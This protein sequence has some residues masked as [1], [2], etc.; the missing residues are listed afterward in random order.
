MT[1]PLHVLLVEDS[2]SDAKLVI[3]EL[4]KIGRPIE[5]ERV[6]TEHS[7]R[8]ALD[9]RA[10]DLVISD[11]SMP[12]FSALAALAVVRGKEL[13]LPFIIVSGTIGE[14]SAVEAMRAGAND[15]VLKD[16][17]GRLAPAIERELRECEER[18]AH[19]LATHE[20]R[21]SEARFGR[22]AESAEDALRRSE[23]QLRQA[24]KME[25]VGRLA[26]GV[27]HD[28]NNIL[29]IILS[30]GELALRELRPGD[31]V[32][33][34]IEQ[35]CN[36]AESA[37][38]LTNQLLMFSRQRVVEPKVLELYQVVVNMEP[39]LQRIVGEDVKL[40]TVAPRS[41]G[42]VKVDPSHI[43]QVILNLIVN[44][45]DAMPKGG[46][47]TI[48]SEDVVLDEGY[49]R[50]HRP[51]RAGPHVMLAVSDT[52]AGMDRETQSRIFE[53][54]FTTKEVGKGTGLGLSTVFGIVQQSGGS[55]WVYSELGQGSTFKVFLPRVDADVDLPKRPSAPTTLHG[56]ETI[57]VVEDDERVREV[58][59]N[60]LERQGYHVLAAGHGE[61]ALRLAAAHPGSIDLLLSD[62]VMPNMGGPELAKRLAVTRP[63]LKLLCM[64]GYTDER[65][66]HHG[67]LDTAAFIQKPITPTA[68]AVK[69][70]ERLDEPLG[71][72]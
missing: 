29:S 35:I 53:P 71:S 5:F 32:R 72:S 3:R 19:R 8:S 27:A 22:L 62:V 17:L 2:A 45:R 42:R 46:T 38:G 49:A 55:I 67:V 11:W 66:I 41:R 48:E 14:D 43:E 18:R 37:A 34:D 9:R 13:D 28:F 40:I 65:I 7:M 6:E 10:W 25:A 59:V 16:R 58:V 33:R 68:L 52:G 31:P 12:K 64:S 23:E 21:E 57:L 70:R 69:V 15:Y 36:A 50:E 51:S 60:I 30:Y 54:F 47:V 63:T 4:N 26:G 1:Q 56:S 24:Q 39:M 61:E 44:A 20:L